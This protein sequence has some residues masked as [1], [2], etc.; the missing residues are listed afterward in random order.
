[1]LS[2]N[3]ASNIRLLFYSQIKCRVNMFKLLH[4]L[5]GNTDVSVVLE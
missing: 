5:V 3:N 1:M 2:L 4:V